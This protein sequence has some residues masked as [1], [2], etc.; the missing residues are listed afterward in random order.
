MR[1]IQA[2]KKRIEAR[3][4]R[5]AEDE[6]QRRAS[7]AEERKAQGKKPK[8]Y[9]KRKYTVEPVIGWIK[10]CVGFREFSLRGL[11]KAAAEWK[12]VCLALNIRRMGQMGS[13][14]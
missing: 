13:P 6:E 14:C 9:R 11:S 8:R 1:A 12:L 4:K 3:A 7:E 2:A 10:A 5:R